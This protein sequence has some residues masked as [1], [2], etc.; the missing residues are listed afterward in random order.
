MTMES[1]PNLTGLP[2]LVAERIQV[3][4]RSD[5]RITDSGGFFGQGDRRTLGS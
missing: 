4:T 1:S 3:A 2:L 5:G